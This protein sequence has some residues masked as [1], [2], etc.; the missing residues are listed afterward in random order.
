MHD[1]RVG[2]FFAVDPLTKKYPF[3]S[4]YQFAG[5]TPIQSI[6]LEGLED[7]HYTLS[8]NKN[9]ENPQLKLVSEQSDLIP[10]FISGLYINDYYV[11]DY[12]TPE[13]AQSA[14][15]NYYAKFTREQWSKKIE[16][17]QSKKEAYQK[18]RFD[19]I[20]PAMAAGFLVGTATNKPSDVK[21][22]K[23]K[24]GEVPI[25]EKSV[26]VTRVQTAH[27]LSKRIS[28][29][30]SGNVKIK[31][32]TTLYI[33][34]DDQ[35]HATYYYNKKGAS[36]GGASITSFKITKQVAD[37]IR[38][39]AVPQAEGRNYPNR[40]QQVDKGKSLG[41][42]GLPASYIDKL[43]KGVIQGSGKVDQP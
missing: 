1:P 39:M 2:R 6:D 14:A 40:P 21:T 23:S 30:G 15:E 34:I 10:G 27:K 35:N 26:T 22:Q 32:K 19:Y 18:Q 24:N 16:T 8:W 9:G 43:E 3:Y 12:M 29:D 17:E 33:T 38:S 41:A 31:G 20:E 5:N 7:Y 13:K 37:E 11:G 4:P 36:E 42:Y 28:V 25:E